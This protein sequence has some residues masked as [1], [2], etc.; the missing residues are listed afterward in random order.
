MRSTHSA[1]KLIKDVAQAE[2]LLRYHQEPKGRID[3]RIDSFGAA[4]RAGKQ[5]KN[6]F[7]S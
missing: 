3:A 6:L 1:N 5:L 4:T 2:D 7:V